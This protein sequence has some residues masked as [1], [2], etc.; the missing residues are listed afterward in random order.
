MTLP[1]DFDWKK[2]I[3]LNDDV[4][5]AYKT[6]QEA[7]HHYLKDGMYQSRI[8]KSEN[9]PDDFDW[10]IYLALNNDVYNCCK[11]KTSALMHYE[12]YGY[13]EERFYKLKDVNLPED[14]NWILYL[15]NNKSLNL[16]NKNKIEA[17][18]H[19]Y[20]KGKRKNLVYKDDFENVPPNF[21]WILYKIFNKKLMNINNEFEAKIHYEEEGYKLKLQC[22]IPDSIIPDDFDWKTYTEINT[23][24]KQSYNSESL[25]K[26]HY[27]LT[28]KNEGR[29]YKFNHTPVDFDWTFYIKLNP[30]ISENYK[31]NEYTVKL[32]YDLFGKPQNLPYKCNFENIPDDFDWEKY[33]KLNDDLV[34][35][36]DE[37]SCKI[38]YNNYGIYQ[39]RRYK[40]TKNIDNVNNDY[41]KYPFLFHKYILNITQESKTINYEVIL[42]NQTKSTYL[43]T[44]IHCYNIDKF[45]HFFENYINTITKNCELVIIT[46]SV[47]NIDNI[48]IL[49]NTNVVFLKCLNQ[50]MDIGGK[51][52]CMHYINA[53]KI[54]YDYILFLHSKTDDH[55]RRLYCDP[56][57]NNLDNII[58]FTKIDKNI[59]IFTSPLIYMGDYATVI[60]NNHYIDPKNITCKWNFG[61]SLY[62]NDIDR[63]MNLDK[64]TFLFP[65]GNCFVCNKKIASELYG[66][67]LLYNLLNSKITF[68]AVWV[69]S[70]YASRGFTDIGN[71]IHEIFDY[72]KTNLNNRML[73][74]NNI[75][76]GAGHQGHADNMFEHCFERIV[77]KVVKKLKFKIK[78]LSN[79][80][81]DLFINKLDK[82]TNIINSLL[83]A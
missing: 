40:E 83:E 26:Y 58:S 67:T 65:E 82:Y 53:E 63:Y 36:R 28:G 61:N 77:F 1:E 29:I 64:S 21:D 5:N 30:T 39:C 70:F 7:E 81:D 8:Y 78:L 80:G 25:A 15:Y 49:I 54:Q 52:A 9:I 32:H 17:V 18:Y 71:S 62:I 34:K 4:K 41:L 47:G 20:K 56:L 22:N 6:Q 75:A 48:D 42:K 73:Y 51:F 66:D 60:Y 43:L 74:P 16:N 3:E 72:F 37:L 79:E 57:I 2:Y 35:C 55:V 69:K 11:D 10:E 19:Y 76:W 31:I 23:D 44:H 12:L 24:V 13:K 46:F 38:H 33:L 45:N 27:Y 68:D 59:G 14:F 50:G